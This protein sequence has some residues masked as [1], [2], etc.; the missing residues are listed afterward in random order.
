[1]VSSSSHDE[2]NL[3]AVEKVLGDPAFAEFSPNTWKIRT[4]LIIASVISIAVVFAD[5]HIDPG[6][7]VLG[8]KFHGLSDTVLTNG[9]FGVTLYLLLHFLWSAVD[10]LLEW[11]LRIT[12]TKV[13]FATTGIFASEHADYPRD[14]R[15]STLYNWW[16]DEATKIGDLTAKLSEIETQLAEWDARLKARFTEGPDAMN[17]VNASASINSTRE[18]VVKLE[19]SM[20]ETRD[21]ISAVRVPVS[22]RRFD[23]WFQLFLRSQNLRWLI[24]EFRA[25]ILVGIYALV[26]LWNR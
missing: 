12:G 23:R 10:T 2:D 14:P 5:L 15:Q 4:Y 20:T 16:K 13:A 25:P 11:R 22:L 3:K 26:L 1:M 9:L 8:L 7:T 17:I 21:A 19:R 18:A 24:I 6:S